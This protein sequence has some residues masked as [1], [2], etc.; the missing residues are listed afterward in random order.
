MRFR[1]V[2]ATIEPDTVQFSALRQPDLARVVEQNY[3][4]RLKLADKLLDKYIDREIGVVTQDGETV[5][6]NTL[7]FDPNQ[8]ILKT[9]SVVD[10][11]PR[12]VN[13]R[14][15]QFSVCPQDC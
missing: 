9:K 7:S 6:G 3:E 8:L 11:L 1:D 15:V 10:L 13:V 4:F 5:K 14:D 2:A 12:T